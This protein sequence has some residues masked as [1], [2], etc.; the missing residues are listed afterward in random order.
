MLRVAFACLLFAWGVSAQTVCPPTPRYSPCDL[1]FDIPTSTTDGSLKLQ[2]EFR[3]PHHD[4]ALVRAVWDGGAK[5]LIR[6]T[7]TEAGDYTYRLTSDDASFQGKEG[8]FA[9]TPNDR[10]GWLRAAVV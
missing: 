4:T 8:K 10:A 9:A 6:Y 3:S 5:W 2:A 7:P 1:T